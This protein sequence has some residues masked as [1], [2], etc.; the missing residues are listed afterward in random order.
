MKTPQLVAS[1]KP[2]LHQVKVLNCY[3]KRNGYVKPT[4]IY[5]SNT[6]VYSRVRKMTFIEQPTEKAF[7]AAILRLAHEVL[8]ESEIIKHY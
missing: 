5:C 3:I 7:K 4:G 8:V 6:F 2:G 1:A